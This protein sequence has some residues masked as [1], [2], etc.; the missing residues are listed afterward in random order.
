MYNQKLQELVKLLLKCPMTAK[1]IFIAS[2][3]FS[4]P[5][6]NIGNLRNELKSYFDRGILGR[7]PIPST[8]RGQNEYLYFLARK[9]KQLPELSDMVLPNATFQ[10]YSGSFW[11]SA[12][13]SEFISHWERSAGEVK[14]PVKTLVAIRDGYFKAP[15]DVSFLDSKRTTALLP[16]YTFVVDINGVPNLIFLEVF[17]NPALISPLSPQSVGR[18][19][20]FKFAKYGQFRHGFQ[21]HQIIRDLQQQLDC[22]FS[23]FRVLTVTTR[24]ETHRNSLLAWAR[25]DGYRTMFYFATM[26]DIRKANLFVEPVWALPNGKHRGLSERGV[27][28]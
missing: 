18:S 9:A 4:Y 11:H 27:D 7:Q 28:G 8:N 23:G 15:L 21:A 6:R 3:N 1:M 10:G 20:R 19:V 25:K 13:T 26:N 2:S 24:G 22:C 17:N 12:A 14:P 16:D 5:Y